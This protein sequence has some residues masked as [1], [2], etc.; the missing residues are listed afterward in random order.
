MKQLSANQILDILQI[1]RRRFFILLKKFKSSP[2]NFTVAYQRKNQKRISQELE[3]IILKELALDKKL[4]RDRNIPLTS[5]NYSYIKHRIEDKYHLKVSSP[6]IIKR[7]KENDF[8]L[9]KKERKKHD[10]EVLTNYPGELIQHD[11]SHHL[12]APYSGEKWYLITSIDDYSRYILYAKFL[13]KE[14]TWAHI[15][16]LEST[17]SGYGIPLKYYVDC[18]SIFRFVQGRDS[19]WR[20]HRKLTDQATPQF[21][22][23]LNDLNIDIAY[24][25]SPQAKGKIER[26]YQWMQDRVIRTCARENVKD[27]IKGQNILGAEIDRYNNKQKHSTTDEVPV[28]RLQNA[29]RNNQSLFREYKISTPYQSSKDIFCLRD[30]R[31]VDPYHKI[32]IKNQ[33]LKIRGVPLREQVEIRIVPDMQKGVSEL[34]FWYKNKLV[35]LHTMKNS[36]LDIVQF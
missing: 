29:I 22:Q 20:N 8:Y 14:T 11:S 24:A 12:F 30:K 21:K 32:S 7:A 13:K 33:Q 27:I 17:V 3:N 2:D 35:D 26:P 16:A 18:H 19:A 10:R 28:K 25:L 1:K 34:R 15:M 4:I 31:I 36:D 5:Y 23:V 6:T 9:P